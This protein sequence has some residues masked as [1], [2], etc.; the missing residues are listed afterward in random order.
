MAEPRREGEDHPSRP[1][2]REGRRRTRA[3]VAWL[4]ASGLQAERLISSPYTRALQTAWLVHEGGLSPAPEAS[5]H[6]V[7]GG[8]LPVL[9]RQLQGCCVLVGHEPDLSAWA[10]L[11]IGAPPG[12]LRLRKAGCCRLRI[13]RTEEGRVVEAQ[14]DWLLR[15]G[16]LRCSA[17]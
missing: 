1:L 11:L 7:P 4:A 14:L 8:D 15:P 3:M 13:A 16:L 17:D 10:S 9:L 6:L 12:G 2:T 5:S